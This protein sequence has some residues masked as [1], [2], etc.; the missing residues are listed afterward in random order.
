MSFRIIV[1]AFRKLNAELSWGPRLEDILRNSAW[2]LLE[3]PGTIGSQPNA[4]F[5]N[6]FDASVDNTVTTPPQFRDQDSC[7][8]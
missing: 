2:L 1:G 4:V 3:K 8:T 7:Q 5:P 6:S